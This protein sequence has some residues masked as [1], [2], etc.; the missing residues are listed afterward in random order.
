MRLPS[1]SLAIA[2][3]LV[4]YLYVRKCSKRAAPSSPALML[5]TA[6]QYLQA[7]TGSRVD[8]TLTFFMTVAFFEFLAIAER[9]EH[10]HHDALS[11]PRARRLTKGPVGAALPALGR[12]RLGHPD[13]AL[14]GS[15]SACICCAARSSSGIIGRRM[16]SSRQ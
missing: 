7:G 5:G 15:S 10:S 8:M 6:F 13:L 11:R 12:H 9:L 1:A 2:G 16:V 14:G 3:M 4:T